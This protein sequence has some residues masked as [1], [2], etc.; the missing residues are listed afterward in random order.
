M[1]E[2]EEVVQID[3]A[4]M[5]SNDV[6]V[7]SQSENHDTNHK[8]KDDYFDEDDLID[9]TEETNFIEEVVFS[10]GSVKEN[11][12]KYTRKFKKR[13]ILLILYILVLLFLIFAFLLLLSIYLTENGYVMQFLTF[14]ENIGM[15]INILSTSFD[16]E[17]TTSPLLTT[18][19]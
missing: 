12:L 3:L 1:A 14:I 16:H 10:E 4:I 9:I 8:N 5:G 2:P 13:Y 6:E 19:P 18:L 15:K 17:K 7:E 11:I